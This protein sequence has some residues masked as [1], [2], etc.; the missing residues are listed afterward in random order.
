V[1]V[2]ENDNAGLEVSEQIP[3]GEEPTADT[4]AEDTGA[5]PADYQLD[6]ASATASA[7]GNSTTVVVDVENI[8]DID[9]AQQDVTATALTSDL[10]SVADV[11]KQVTL[12]AGQ[13][14]TVEFTL[15]DGGTSELEAGDQ[16]RVEITLSSGDSVK[17]TAVAE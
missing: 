1:I 17:V 6:S 2:N 9:G 14:D 16:V 13:E 3:L 11:T 10:S 7:A 4:V 12:N 5:E 15:E 8:G